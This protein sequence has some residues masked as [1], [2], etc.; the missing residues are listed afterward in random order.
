LQAEAS[1]L[2]E[3]Y[4]SYTLMTGGIKTIPATKINIDLKTLENGAALFGLGKYVE[5]IK[6]YIQIA[7]Y[8]FNFYE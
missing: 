5:Y 4:S 6:I 7:T 8:F 2:T 3:C 1:E